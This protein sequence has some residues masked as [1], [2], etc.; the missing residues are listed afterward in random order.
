MRLS[1]GQ[2]VFLLEKNVSQHLHQKNKILKVSQ[3]RNRGKLT[4]LR[5]LT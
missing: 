5:S 4:V 2:S 1:T 3:H